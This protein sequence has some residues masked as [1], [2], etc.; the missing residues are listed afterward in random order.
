MET[1]IRVTCETTDRSQ[2]S[3]SFSEKEF[4]DWFR[5]KTSIIYDEDE[6]EQYLVDYLKEKEYHAFDIE[7]EEPMEITSDLKKVLSSD[8][9]GEFQLIQNAIKNKI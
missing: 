1:F 9:L 4:L 7:G 2:V 5:E 8:F 6:I 3:V